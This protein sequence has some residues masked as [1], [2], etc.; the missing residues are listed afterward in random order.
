MKKIRFMFVLLLTAFFFSA[1]D[2]PYDD[3]EEGI[4]DGTEI[5]GGNLVGGAFIG[6]ML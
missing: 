4:D 6:S 1:C 3:S 2:K 5:V